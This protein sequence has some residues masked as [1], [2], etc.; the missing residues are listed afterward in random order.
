MMNDW[1]KVFGRRLLTLFVVGGLFGSVSGC[2]SQDDGAGDAAAAGGD[3]E[4]W[5]EEIVLGLIPVEG[6]ADVAERFK[7]ME[8]HLEEEMGIEVQLRPATS[9]NGVIT[10]MA[11]GQVDFA[12]FG[13]KSYVEAANRAGAEALV[14]ELTEDGRAGYHSVI[15]A[16]RDSGLETLEDARGKRFAFTDPN[17]TSG[18]LIP[19]VYFRDEL[20]TRPEDFFGEIV[21]SGSHG[22]SI[23]QVKNGDIDVAA[24]NDL[25]LARNEQSGNISQDEFVVLWTSD[26]IP[27]SPMAG[28]YDLP[29]SLKEAFAEALL[30]FGEDDP[31]GLRQLQ[32]SGYVRTEDAHYDVIRRL[33]RLESELAAGGAG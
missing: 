17:S 32:L 30:N 6:G 13:P 28:R 24:T 1:C 18:N 2:S 23:L 21:F 5:P 7:P 29:E 15:I 26:L 19:T 16:R 9:Y 22:T 4:A 14:M 20:N 31:R 11:N 10:A 3:G 12:Y 27:A 33:M 8:A 25:D